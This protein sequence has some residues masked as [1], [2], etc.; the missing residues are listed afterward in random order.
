MIE[1]TL[2]LIKPDGVKRNL[3]GKIIQR[4]EESDLKIKAIKM[5]QADESL[6]KNHYALDETWA[7]NVFDKTKASYEKENKP[8]KYKTHIDLGKTIQKWNME[9]L[10]E[11][12]VI[13]IIIEGPHAIELIRKMVGSTEPR[14]AQPGTIRG[15]FASTESYALADSQNRV[16][17]NLIHASDS[18][19]TAQREISL[20]F[21]NEEIHQYKKEPDKHL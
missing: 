3:V 16:L 4:F 2:V 10:T 14:S 12:P 13:A 5:L 9:F 18:Q 11:G 1:Q 21:K 15:D 17:R 19:T 8:F 20:W 6:A 7:K